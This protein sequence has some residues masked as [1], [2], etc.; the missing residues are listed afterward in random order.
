MI[1]V[2]PRRLRSWI[3]AFTDL[4]KTR[5]QHAPRSPTSEGTLDALLQIAYT[6]LPLCIIP[7][8][9]LLSRI[10]TRSIDINV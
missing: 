9:S 3:S 1:V 4:K 7:C 10:F 8:D 6:S 5:V 2:L